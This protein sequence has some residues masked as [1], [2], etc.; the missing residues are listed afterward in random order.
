MAI[1]LYFCSFS[2]HS[3]YTHCLSPCTIILKWGVLIQDL[4][5]RIRRVLDTRAAACP[6]STES[7]MQGEERS[8]LS[9]E[10]FDAV[11]SRY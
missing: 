5:H 2:S 9:Q 4:A 8:Q 3:T 11:S 1:G 6:P 7:P 10:G